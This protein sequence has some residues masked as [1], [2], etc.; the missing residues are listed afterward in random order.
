MTDNDIIAEASIE[1][2]SIWTWRLKIDNKGLFRWYLDG[3][4]ETNLRGCTVAQAE[5]A[6]RRFTD[7]S[8]RGELR[9][10]DASSR[11]GAD[12]EVG[13]RAKVAIG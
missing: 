3:Y 12:I 10:I 4:V 9:I 13:E 5:T 11:I 1:G 8:L 6:L 7:N 2:S